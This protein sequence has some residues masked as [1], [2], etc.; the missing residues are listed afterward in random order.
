MD[1]LQGL[2]RAVGLGWYNF[3]TFDYKKYEHDHNL[4]NG[5]MNWIVPK[6]ILALS[7]PTEDEQCG[8]HPNHFIEPFK[9]MHST[10]II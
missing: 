7:C 6:R 4:A 2:E 1:C 5:D 8:L 9:Q 10:A 3:K